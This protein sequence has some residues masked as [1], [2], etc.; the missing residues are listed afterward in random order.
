[1]S[2]VFRLYK[3][4]TTTYEDWNSSPVFPYIQNNRDTIEDPDGATASHEITS[5]PSPF[6]RIDLVKTAFGEVCKADKATRKVDLDGDTIYHKMVSDSLDV[7][8]IFFNID[9]L[10]GCVELIKW[11]PT[12]MIGELL[13]SDIAG[14]QFLGDSLQ[15]YLVSDGATYNFGQLQNIYLLNYVHGPEPINIIGATSPASLFFSSANDLSY[16][17]DIYFGTDRPFDN[18]FQPL[19]KRDPEFIKY[20]FALQKA[21]PNFAGLFPEVNDYLQETFKALTD[22]TFKNELRNLTAVDIESFETIMVQQ[23]QQNDIVE[24]LGY[25]LRKK[26][27]QQTSAASDFV[28]RTLTPTAMTPMVLPVESGNRYSNLHYTTAKWGKTNAAP[29]Y[30]I[31]EDLSLRVLPNDGA[32]APYLTISD[33]LEEAII[34]VPHKFNS[35][36]YFGGN[37]RNGSGDLAYLLPVKP[38]LF[39]YF[40]P[41]ELRG[42]MPD[43]RYMFEME[44]LAGNLG[45]KVTLRVPIKGAGSIT[46]VEYTRKYYSQ[47]PAD[48]TQNEGTIR[49]FNFT[50]FVMPCIRFNEASDAIYNVGCL[51]GATAKYELQFYV[52]GTKVSPTSVTCRDE[53]FMVKSVNYLIENELF[54]YVQVRNSSGYCGVIMPL[55]KQQQ[56][57]EQF[58]FAID[59]GTSNTHIEFCKQGEAPQAFCFGA[60]ERPLC[61]F[62]LPKR[63]ES[64][65]LEDLIEQ[66]EVLEKDYIPSEVGQLDYRFPT[67]TVLS[68]AKTLSWNSVIAPFMM[69]NLPFT[70]DK[71]VSIQYNN[72]WNNIKWG[73]GADLSRMEAYVK[74]LLLMIRNKVL[75]NQGDL[76]KTTI[77]WFYPISMAPKRYAHLRRTWQDGF[78][79]YFGNGTLR[80]MTESA[81]PIQYFFQRYATA[82]TL[83]NID[84]GGGTSDIA[85]ASNKQITHVTSFRFASNTL[86]QDSFTDLDPNNGIIDYHK[87]MVKNILE[88]Y[89]LDELIKIFDSD[90]NE[91]PANMASFLF[92]LKDNSIPRAAGVGERALDF[93]YILQQDEKFK[94]VFILFYTSI[95]YH[96][97]KI[98]KKFDMEVPRHISFSGNGSKVIK[99][100]TDDPR[101]LA[102]YTKKVF[103]KVLGREYGKELEILGMDKAS[104]PKES[105]CKGG[106]I[107]SAQDGQRVKIIVLKSDGSGVVGLHDT[108]RNITNEYKA[109]VV[110]SVEEFFDFALNTM[111]TEFNFDDNFGVERTSIE[112]AKE[113]ARRDLDTYLEKGIEQRIAETEPDATIEESFFF[114]PIKGVI[115]A[116]SAEIYNKLRS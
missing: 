8:E 87:G 59:L 26:T 35:E 14:H 56:N 114:Y 65:N 16:V 67:R 49:E 12:P 64:G 77:T 4:G 38:L 72:Y 28:I 22:Q 84:I 108:Y 25:Q 66:T 21:I 17:N 24:V 2:K 46:Y 89:R 29:Y 27:A 34:R 18:E 76:S 95:V 101:L 93:N 73:N 85:F 98:I 112:L 47:R 111:N 36:S 80:N 13:A 31:E 42:T 79:K 57:I 10:K 50:G 60:N 30:D 92:S 5:I 55:F 106:I 71:R 99:I 19:Y 116:I 68:A 44:A 41:E 94:V 37:L 61:E 96:I 6:A 63:N 43:G 23:V 104:N 45:V 110:R 20:I 53:N 7:A 90:S 97:A 40:S 115:Q 113:V 78:A 9:K 86:F 100:I 107:G 83:V 51:Q 91:H 75:L 54:D 52:G 39:E 88:D 3:D 109:Q 58:N 105:T 70:Y 15:K 81:A 69:A 1:M 11:D 32:N 82:T 103:E 62:F 74:C 102:R 48:I 33:L